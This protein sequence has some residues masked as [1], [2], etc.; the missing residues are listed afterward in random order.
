MTAAAQADRSPTFAVQGATLFARE[1][2]S[3][4]TVLFVHGSGSDD[5]SWDSAFAAVAARCRA[6]TYSRRHHRPNPPLQPGE[7]YDY[8]RQV[9]DLLAV[10]DQIDGP[11]DLVAHSSGGVLALLA[12]GRR[13]DRVRRL[14]LVEP[15][16]FTLVV[17][18]P[19]RAAEIVRLIAADPRLAAAMIRLAVNSLLPARRAAKRGDRPA[20][21]RAFGG[22]VLGPSAFEALTP[23]R[24]RQVEENFMESELID[25]HMPRLT[26]ADVAAVRCP[27]LVVSGR[28][29]PDVFRRLAQRLAREL[30]RGGHVELPGASHMVHEDAPEAFEA[31]LL[32]FLTRDEPT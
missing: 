15:A 17:S 11:L 28:D 12:A 1:A 8:G 13:S 22:G 14:V 2:G 30:P 21:I 31:T 29:S 32:S 3:G 26:G 7:R 9:D 25:A 6:V 20:A 27:A 18:D 24:A 16:I 10:V 5:R 19:P 4:Q 23:E